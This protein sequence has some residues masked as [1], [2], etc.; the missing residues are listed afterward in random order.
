M[1]SKFKGNGKNRILAVIASAVMFCLVVLLI[2]VTRKTDVVADTSVIINGK[3]YSQ[4]NKMKILEIVSEDYYDE[5]GPIIGNS[6]GSVKWDDIVAKATDKKV[7]SNSDVQ[8]NMDVYLQYVNGI[9][10][11]GTNYNLCL[12]YKSG[13]SYN[14]YTTSNDAIQK[15]GTL[16]VDNIK[17]IFCKKDGNSYIPMTTK[18]GS[19]L[20]DAFSFFV[21]G[22]KGMEGFVDLV[23]KKPSEVLYIF[24]VKFTMPEYYLRIII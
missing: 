14:Y 4:D 21:F 11:N 18:N 2:I 19:K 9:L 16:D 8:K 10:L 12:E 3:E 7:A 1:K 23:I 22:D 13:N 6:S 17:L 5:L 24:H 20:R 15:V